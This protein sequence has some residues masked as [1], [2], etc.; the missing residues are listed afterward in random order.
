MASLDPFKVMLHDIAQNITEDKLD[1]MKH[2]LYP[3][4]LKPTTKAIP[5]R[6][7]KAIRKAEDLFD[8][9]IDL[10]LLTR[11]NTD[12]LKDLLT[13][14]G[15]KKLADAVKDALEPKKEDISQLAS[16]LKELYKTKFAN[17]N[18]LPWNP[19]FK[20][21]LKEVYTQLVVKKT[22]GA[23][24][25]N[26]GENVKREA[27][28][29]TSF[30]QGEYCKRIV[31]K[32]DPAMGKSVFCR[33]LAYDWSCGEL[34]R[35]ESVFLI[36]LKYCQMNQ[37]NIEDIV[38]DQLLPADFKFTREQLRHYIKNETGSI[39][40]IFDGYDEMIADIKTKH[41]VVGQIIRQKLLYSCTALIT[42]RP[43]EQEKDLEDCNLWFGIKGFDEEKYQLYM[44]KYFQ[45]REHFA[46]GLIEEVKNF[47]FEFDPTLLCNP[48]NVSFLCAI[49]EDVASDEHREL[50]F[51]QKITDLYTE[52]YDCVISRFCNRDQGQSRQNAEKVALA[53]ARDTHRVYTSKNREEKVLQFS[54]HD[55]E[56]TV[57][58]KL[59][60][61]VQDVSV[62][63]TQPRNIYFFIHRTWQEYFLA[64]HISKVIQGDSDV[65]NFVERMM[66]SPENNSPTIRFLSGLLKADASTLFEI[67]AHKLQ[68]IQAKR[69]D[70]DY[71]SFRTLSFLL[72]FCF[73]CLHEC[74]H[75]SKF[76]SVISYAVPERVGVG[77]QYDS[78]MF[79]QDWSFLFND[80]EK[81]PVAIKCNSQSFCELLNLVKYQ[82]ERGPSHKEEKSIKDLV[83]LLKGRNRT[84]TKEEKVFCQIDK[85]SPLAKVNSLIKCNQSL[86]SLSICSIDPNIDDIMKMAEYIVELIAKINSLEDL[87]FGCFPRYQI[88]P[89]SSLARVTGEPQKDRFQERLH[90]VIQKA[91][92]I[93]VSRLRLALLNVDSSAELIPFKLI[94][95][96]GPKTIGLFVHCSDKRAESLSGMS[97]FIR[98]SKM[99][100]DVDIQI[101][102][103]EEDLENLPKKYDTAFSN[104]S[105]AFRK[106]AFGIWNFRFLSNNL[107]IIPH[108]TILQNLSKNQNLEKARFALSG[109]HGLHDIIKSNK[110][111]KSLT[112]MFDD[113]INSSRYYGEYYG[114]ERD[115]KAALTLEDFTVRLLNKDHMNC[116]MPEAKPGRVL[117]STMRELIGP[118]SETMINGECSLSSVKFDYVSVDEDDNIKN[119]VLRL[120]KEN[121]SSKVE[122]SYKRQ[123]LFLNEYRHIVSVR[124][125]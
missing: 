40:F 72:Q 77:I 27:D 67:F 26:T 114:L 7:L 34:Q 104:A 52:I 37:H 31:V 22:V 61:L 39:L 36:Q 86:K 112:V 4:D 117:M 24:R 9:M 8:K 83:L 105:S 84:N 120:V 11:D 65:R 1:E 75:G 51:P 25:F 2:L 69:S 6:D 53:L 50:R 73:E 33:K 115:L 102:C 3:T 21:S 89:M 79:W 14:V 107:M 17:F 93:G 119:K 18:P 45:G 118:V 32:G 71:E 5:A 19:N 43:H 98:C 54:D 41:S 23:S 16:H 78:Q 70:D 85:K 101:I 76:M 103:E 122:W 87:F 74:G 10:R 20:I 60:F 124:R 91:T 47:K 12:L 30:S 42:T 106:I 46:N 35:F 111:L 123:C 121:S 59:G 125:L 63:R 81:P 96:T 13:N 100:S 48:L 82:G 29:F 94:Q 44:Q 64:L 99:A 56:D 38:F 49:W 116:L 68:R 109:T 108:R 58:I 97:E 95:E 66:E 88:P 113:D 15:L 28:I 62:S 57:S 55:I 80:L 90:E 110:R 92:D